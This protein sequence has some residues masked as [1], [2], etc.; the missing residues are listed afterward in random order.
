MWAVTCGACVVGLPAL[1]PGTSSLSAIEGSP[2]CEP[3][4]SQV[5]AI[6]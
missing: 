2:L 6:R 5:A 4:F 3:A 1:E